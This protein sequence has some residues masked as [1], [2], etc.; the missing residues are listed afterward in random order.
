M[1]DIQEFLQK[2][3]DA[4]PFV[5]T[6]LHRVIDPEVGVN[7]VDLGLVRQVDVSDEGDVHIAM[8]LTTPACPLGPYMTDSIQDVLGEASWVRHVDTDIVWEP[9]WDPHR[10]MTDIAKAQLGWTR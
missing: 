9:L 4:R 1:A 7:I 6:L 5:L 2:P 8:T 3:A 10:D